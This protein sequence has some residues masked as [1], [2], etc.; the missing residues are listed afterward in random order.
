MPKTQIS[1]SLFET[2]SP[3]QAKIDTGSPESQIA[4]FTTRIHLI[5]QHLK[6]HNKDH[7]SRLGLIKLVGKRKKQLS[8]LTKKDPAR[9]KAICKNL[10]LRK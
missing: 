8:Y 6:T 1:P 5:N 2:H 3:T 7:K 10:S 4:V 9:Y